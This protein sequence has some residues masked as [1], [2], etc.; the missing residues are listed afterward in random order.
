[1]VSENSQLLEKLKKAESDLNA[2]RRWNSS[3]KVLKWLN[4]YHSRNKKGLGFVS[5]RTV[6]PINKKYV[7]LQEYIICFHFGKTGYYCYT[8][9]L[10]KNAMER[11]AIYVKQMWVRKDETCLSR[12]M[13]PKWI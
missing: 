1:L 8:C 10:R 7:G 6:N 4:T 12:R 5:R 3:S 9:P 2:N 11:S 13:G